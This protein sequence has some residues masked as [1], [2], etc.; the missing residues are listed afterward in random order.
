MV[1]TESQPGEAE[2]QGPVSKRKK[3]SNKANQTKPWHRSLEMG[4]S[5]TMHSAE[6]NRYKAGCFFFSEQGSS[7]YQSSTGQIGQGKRRCRETEN[8]SLF[9]CT[10]RVQ[11][12]PPPRFSLPAGQTKPA[13]QGGR[14]HNSTVWHQSTRMLL[15]VSSLGTA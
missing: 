6:G 11:E 15:T 13:R 9:C 4:P 5:R 14:H 1:V 2:G 12:P 10:Q 8:Q 3:K 7:V